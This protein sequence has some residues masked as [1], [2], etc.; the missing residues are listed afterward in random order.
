LIDKRLEQVSHRR[1]PVDKV[2]ALVERYRRQQ[3]GWNV[4]PFHATQRGQAQLHLGQ[5][6]AAR[7]RCGTKAPGRGKHRKRRTRAA[8]PG[9]MLHQDASPHE[10]VPGVKWGLV[11]TMDDA[12]NE[13]YSMRLVAEEGTD[14]SFM[15]VRGVIRQR[16]LFASLYTDRGSHYWYTRKLAA[17]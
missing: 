3:A 7:G 17:R 16:G 8:G 4:K 14:S 15:G 5:E 1:A 12:T 9:M 13:H 10:W 11:V 6:P 2:M